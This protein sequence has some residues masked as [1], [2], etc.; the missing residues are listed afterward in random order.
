MGCVDVPGLRPG[1]SW[2][3]QTSCC[4]TGFHPGVRAILRGRGEKALGDQGFF[5]CSSPLQPKEP[6]KSCGDF[7]FLQMLPPAALER[8]CIARLFLDNSVGRA[9]TIAI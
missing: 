3:L 7:V 1:T 2:R 4:L 5:F 6:A 9:Y 8:R